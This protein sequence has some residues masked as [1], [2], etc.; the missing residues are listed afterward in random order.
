MVGPGSNDGGNG[1]RS[2]PHDQSGLADGGTFSFSQI[3][4]DNGLLGDGEDTGPKKQQSSRLA[5]LDRLRAVTAADAALRETATPQAGQAQAGVHPDVLAPR[6][7]GYREQIYARPPMG[8]GP[9]AR[10]SP[11]LGAVRRNRRSIVLCTLL[12]GM[13]GLAMAMFAGD[14]YRSTS[15][16]VLDP[17]AL[18]VSNPEFAAKPPTDSNLRILVSRQLR[19]LRS[20][21]VLQTVA[22]EL[23]LQ[24]DPEFS[25]GGGGLIS[26]IGNAIA[27]LI[28]PGTGDRSDVVAALARA[29]TVSR[30]DS[31]YIL[32]IQV[33]TADPAKSAA[34]ADGIAET[35]L[36]LQPQVP[37]APDADGTVDFQQQLE[38]FRLDAEAAQ[39]RL[40]A[41]EAEN[42]TGQG[43]QI[44]K[45][46][47]QLAQLRAEKDVTRN[48]ALAAA[49]LNADQ[50]LSEPLPDFVRDT[51]LVNLW[52]QYQEARQSA[53]R[54][55]T[56][57]DAAD[58]SRVTA[59]ETV[60]AL[61]SQFSRQLRVFISMAQLELRRQI[62]LEQELA[63]ELAILKAEPGASS[64]IMMRKRALEQAASAA[65]QAYERLRENMPTGSSLVNSA[66][67]TMIPAPPSVDTVGPSL[68]A[69]AGTGM[70]TGLAGGLV[71]TLFAGAF[72]RKRPNLAEMARPPVMPAAAAPPLEPDLDPNKRA[73][74]EAW[75]GLEPD[76][77][78]PPEA[79]HTE[80]EPVQ[81]APADEQ[82]VSDLDYD[83]EAE[84]IRAEIAKMRQMVEKMQ[85]ANRR[86][87]NGGKPPRSS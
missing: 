41:F 22:S 20:D 7:Q 26:G 66:V 33:V 5:A 74:E 4:E 24:A 50:L 32:N 67:G 3:L 46:E 21:R 45:L 76:T 71:I 69:Y 18:R 12:G 59:E 11:F 9:A 68:A 16:L 77:Q 2:F 86:S 84:A 61:R 70:A 40:L 87:P 81:Q 48:T 35:Y 17:R 27:N 79:Q 19:A 8:G 83:A 65:Q 28:G 10:P 60:S 6:P 63:S 62:E 1:G 51:T 72:R 37:R 31:D 14:S 56:T 30:D 43:Q 58:P 13:V 85:Q 39:Q 80:A 34:I 53:D 82:D 55:T 73:I 52:A 42:G 49:Q 44:A 47:A 25:A 23:N 57:L 36:M 75:A 64:D 38:S 29:V 54:L 15:Q 78:Q